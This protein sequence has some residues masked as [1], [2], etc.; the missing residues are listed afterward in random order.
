MENA[1]KH[2]L[3]PKVAGGQV[4]VQASRHGEQ[5]RLD[6]RDTGVGLGSGGPATRGTQFG[7][8]HISERLHAV[9]GD[10]ATFTLQAAGDAQG[11]TLARI[12]LP[13]PLVR[14]DVSTPA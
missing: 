8:H 11:G 4:S 1:I 5:L 7:T 9:Y 2:G 12:E 13:W 6:V 10:A 14:P 3:E